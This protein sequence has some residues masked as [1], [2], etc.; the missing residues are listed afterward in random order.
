MHPLKDA[1]SVLKE[2]VLTIKDV[3][4]LDEKRKELLVLEAKSLKAD[5]WENQEEARRVMRAIDALKSDISSVTEAESQIEDALSVVGEPS[6]EGE[7]TKTIDSVTQK[8]DKLETLT[9]LSGAFD[10]SDAIISIHA[11]QGGTEA[12]DWVSMLFRMYLRFAERQGWDAEVVDQTPGEEAGLKSVTIFVSGQYS[13][14][15]LKNEARTH[16]LVR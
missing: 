9:Y 3:L 12:M 2:R 11:G 8:L 15:Y 6:L 10:K 13:Y 4:N 5:F 1:L 14:G 16:R 7:V